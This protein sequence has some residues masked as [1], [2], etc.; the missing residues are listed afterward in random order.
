[1]RDCDAC[2]LNKGV[3]YDDM[4]AGSFGIVDL[5]KSTCGIDSLCGSMSPP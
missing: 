1:M 5:E 4:S 3:E 2:R